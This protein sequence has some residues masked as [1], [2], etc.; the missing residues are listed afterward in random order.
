[1]FKYSDWLFC[2]IPVAILTYILHVG[3]SKMGKLHEYLLG[4][5]GEQEMVYYKSRYNDHIKL[6]INY[7]KE[8]Y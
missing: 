5:N 3:S 1:M 4:R 2:L 7:F 6:L 8:D